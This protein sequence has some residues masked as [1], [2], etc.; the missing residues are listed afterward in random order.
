MTESFPLK[1]HATNNPVGY[2]IGTLLELDFTGLGKGIF[3]L[4]TFRDGV[5]YGVRGTAFSLDRSLPQ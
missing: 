4:A 2:P 3:P 5:W 1:F